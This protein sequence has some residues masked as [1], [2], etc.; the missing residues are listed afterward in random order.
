MPPPDAGARIGRGDLGEILADLTRSPTA[1]FEL[2]LAHFARN[3]LVHCSKKH[4]N[5]DL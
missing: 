4:I 1:S 3:G 5:L 2:P